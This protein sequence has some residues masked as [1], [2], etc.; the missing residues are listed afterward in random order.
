MAKAEREPIVPGENEWTTFPYKPRLFDVAEAFSSGELTYDQNGS[1]SIKKP[2]VTGRSLLVIP[3]ERQF[4]VIRQTYDDLSNVVSTLANSPEL[5]KGGNL[6]GFVEEKVTNYYQELDSAVESGFPEGRI[7]NFLFDPRTESLVIVA[8]EDVHYLALRTSNSLYKDQK[9]KSLFEIWQAFRDKTIAFA[10]ASVGGNILEGA[11]RNI[12][13]KNI[14]LADFDYATAG[15]ITRLNRGNIFHLSNP[16]SS[17]GSP[18]DPY[19]DQRPSKAAMQAREMLLIDPYMNLE[20]CEVA[21]SSANME[22]FFGGSDLIVEAI[23]NLEMKM[24][25]RRLARRK[26]IPLLMI[27]DVDERIFADFYDFKNNS[28]IN[29]VHGISDKN[30]EVMMDKA[31]SGTREQNTQLFKT[32]IGDEIMN[33][34]FGD[35][36]NGKG[37]HATASIPQHGAT[38]LGAGYVA[39]VIIANYILG[40]NIPQRL[41]IDPLK[42]QVLRN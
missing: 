15:N 29:L 39:S 32:L 9:G 6:Q 17:K 38:A 41:L 3:P 34:S 36:I 20:V 31:R 23:D 27:S 2:E 42:Q 14:K 26:R 35:W 8:P 4:S 37:E 19:E 16:R 24:E 5:P 13:P 10:G 25:I 22:K 40:E 1:A 18:L 28:G 33:G 7:G 11:V 21:L 30:L 12:G